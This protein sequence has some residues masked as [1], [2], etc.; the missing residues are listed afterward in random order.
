MGIL[1]EIITVRLGYHKSCL[2]FDFLQKYLKD[3]DQFLNYIVG[4]TGDKT[5]KTVDI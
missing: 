3:G 2:N 4:V 5:V 1:Y